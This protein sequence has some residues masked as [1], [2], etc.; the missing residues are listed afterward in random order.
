VRPDGKGLF[1]RSIIEPWLR[2]FI[3]AQ[4]KLLELHEA[5]GSAN[6]V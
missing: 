3:S 4:P 5:K 1:Y 6:V 2:G